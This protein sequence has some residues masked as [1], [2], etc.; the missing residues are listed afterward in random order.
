MPTKE[1]V[2]EDKRTSPLA[3]S[4]Q[5]FQTLGHR[6]VDQIAALLDSFPERPITP[7]ETPAAIRQALNSDRP[8]PQQGTDPAP[9]LD[10]AAN[11]LFD[12]SLFNGHPRFWGYITGSPAPIG[13]LAE[14][15]AASVNPN[16]GAWPLSPMA[17][18]I[19]AQTIRWIAEMLGY[20]TDCGGLFVSGGNM[21]NLVC[22][23]AARQAKAG[24][25][26]RTK[27]ISDTR[28]RLYCSKETHTWIQKAADLSGLGTDAIRWIPTNDQLQIDTAALREQTPQRHRSRRQTVPRHRHRR[29]RRHWSNRRPSRTLR[30]LPRTQSLVPRRRSLRRP[31]RSVTRRSSHTQGTARSRLPRRRSAQMALRPARSRMRSRPRSAGTTRRLRLPAAY[32]HFGSEAINYFDLGP[33][34][35][36]GFRALKVWLALQHVGREGYIQ[37][38]SD[39]IR[40]A[41]HL[42]LEI[43]KYPQAGT[44]HPLAKY[45]DIPLRPH[46]SQPKRRSHSPAT[47]TTST[48]NSSLNCKTAAKPTSPTPS[49]TESSPY[50]PAS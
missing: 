33:Q 16:V 40:L 4:S 11:L 48:A 27:G 20:P 43:H 24:S 29:L 1:A 23:F 41:Q 19:E 44:A 6:L 21:A 2:D 26:I 46:R 38:L 5:E 13:I 35:S 14:L 50:A 30:H 9:L 39:D 12:H 37:M 25:N 47:S 8:I 7:A 28:L 17:S 18:E 22:F 32:Y 31:R 42:F 3:M 45:H 49:S 15:L 10:H 34:N 36:R